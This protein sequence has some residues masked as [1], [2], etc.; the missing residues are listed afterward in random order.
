MKSKIRLIFTP[1]TLM[2]RVIKRSKIDNFAGG[3]IFGAI[4]SLLVNVFT[5]RIQEDISKQR[6]LESIEREIVYHSLTINELTRGAENPTIGTDG[7]LLVDAYI[8][9][10]LSTKIWDNSQI[11][12]YLFELNPDTAAKVELYYDIL[13]SSINRQLNE[14]EQNYKELYAPCKPFYTLMTKQK[15][16]T[17]EEC[18]QIASVMVNQ[19][20]YVANG[21]FDN[22]QEIKEIFHPTKDRLNNIWL[23][24]ILGDKSINILR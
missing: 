6:T 4:F 9:K 21:I 10:R 7:Y 17:V 3:I 14:N 18:N 15:A 23:R 20:S 19:H 2:H 11:Y 16:K 13:V 5:V 1:F 8:S 12:N 24:T 22:Y